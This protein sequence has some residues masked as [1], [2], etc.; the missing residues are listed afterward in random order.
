MIKKKTTIGEDDDSQCCEP[1]ILEDNVVMV[2]FPK[3]VGIQNQV[4]HGILWKTTKMLFL[5][6]GKIEFLHMSFMEGNCCDMTGT[7]IE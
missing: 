4:F 7:M 2:V 5:P 3:M 6:K 1:D